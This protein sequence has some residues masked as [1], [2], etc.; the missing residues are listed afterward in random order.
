MT[1]I[2]YEQSDVEKIN[3]FFEQEPLIVCALNKVS[4]NP[5][6]AMNGP[7]AKN[8]WQPQ[9]FIPCKTVDDV[10]E[11][12]DI[13]ND[14]ALLTGFD[15]FTDQDALQVEAIF[16][17]HEQTIITTFE[18][19]IKQRAIESPVTLFERFT[20]GQI[21]NHSIEFKTHMLNIVCD[22]MIFNF[23]HWMY[24]ELSHNIEEEME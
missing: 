3:Q 2:K 9:T 4:T 11:I 24:Y 6:W 21:Y 7:D 17:N 19:I 18:K 20:F 22:E 14:L 23:Y 1:N 10:H 16:A 13:V 5:N 12:A 8:N 15:Q